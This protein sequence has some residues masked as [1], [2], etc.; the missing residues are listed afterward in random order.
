MVSTYVSLNIRDLNVSHS[1]L[2]HIFDFLLYLNLVIF[3]FLLL[4]IK[5]FHHFIK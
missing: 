4:Y 2:V 3:S 1:F 5:L